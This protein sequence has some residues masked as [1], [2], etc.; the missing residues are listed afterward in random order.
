[1]K[2]EQGPSLADFVIGIV[3]IVVILWGAVWMGAGIWGG[4]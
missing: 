3:G 1:M 4:P 2:H